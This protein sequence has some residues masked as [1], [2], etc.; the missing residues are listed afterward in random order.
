MIFDNNASLEQDRGSVTRWLDQ[1]RQV[2]EDQSLEREIWSRYFPKLAKI[3][4]GNFLRTHCGWSMVKT[5]H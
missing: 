2:G 5:S 1:L 3:A 4:T